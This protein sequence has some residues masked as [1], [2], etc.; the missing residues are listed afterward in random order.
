MCSVSCM[1]NI[2]RTPRLLMDEVLFGSVWNTISPMLDTDD[3]VRMR[4]AA[5]C[6]NDGRRHGKM[7]KFSS[8]C[9]TAILS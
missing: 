7:A 9:C 5:K 8:N 4:V 3:V 2:A 1:S 6:W